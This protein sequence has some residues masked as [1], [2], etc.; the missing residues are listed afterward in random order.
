[1]DGQL[2]MSVMLEAIWMQCNEPDFSAWQT[3]DFCQC[4]ISMVPS[5]LYLEFKKVPSSMLTAKVNDDVQH[6]CRSASEDNEA[7]LRADERG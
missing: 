2:C 7:T 5:S 6:L 3:E 1:M 4:L